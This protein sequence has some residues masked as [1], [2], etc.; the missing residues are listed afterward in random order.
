MTKITNEDLLQAISKLSSESKEIK[1]RLDGLETR[2]SN[3]EVALLEFKSEVKQDL[4][5]LDKKFTI[6]LEDLLEA[7]TDI[8]LL[9]QAHSS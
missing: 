9:Q 8:T 6:V 5:K 4:R 7:R 2:I 1:N 3:V